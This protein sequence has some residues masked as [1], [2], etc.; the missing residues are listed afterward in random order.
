M[1]FNNPIDFFTDR[2]TA[3]RVQRVMAAYYGH[4]PLATTQE[5]ENMQYGLAQDPNYGLVEPAAGPPALDDPLTTQMGGFLEYVQALRRNHLRGLYG[6]WEEANARFPFY[7]RAADAARQE[8]A[9]HI[10]NAPAEGPTIGNFLNYGPNNQN[11]N[12]PMPAPDNENTIAGQ[13]RVG[14]AVPTNTEDRFGGLRNI[15]GVAAQLRELTERARDERLRDAQQFRDE[16]QN[17]TGGGDAGWRPI[18]ATEARARGFNVPEPGL[19]VDDGWRPIVDPVRNADGTPDRGRPAR[20]TPAARRTPRPTITP[21]QHAEN[22]KAAKEAAAW[23]GDSTK[24]APWAAE[25]PGQRG[26]GKPEAARAPWER[27]G[28]S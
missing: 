17:F 12:A 3:D 21:E 8:W 13:P 18:D 2:A 23:R 1:P 11:Q 4:E 26:R 16:L 15:A 7:D 25:R 9:Q 20:V 14:Q 19:P 10:S 5:I 22:I 24:D 28:K 27:P 6:N